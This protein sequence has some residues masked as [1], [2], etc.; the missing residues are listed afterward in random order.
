MLLPSGYADAS[1]I[2]MK[3]VHRPTYRT[4]ATQHLVYFSPI[5]SIWYCLCVL[6]L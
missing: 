5:L 6:S 1:G 4:L 3:A 2:E